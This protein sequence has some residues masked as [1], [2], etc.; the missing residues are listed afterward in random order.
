MEDSH[1]ANPTYIL[2]SHLLVAM[3]AP[4]ALQSAF[5]SHADFAV[6][7]QAPLSA[8]FRQVSQAS[9]IFGSVPF[10]AQKLVAHSV[11]HVP[12]VAQTQYAILHATC[13]NS[14]R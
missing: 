5:P 6:A 8:V 10:C 12:G 9:P 4:M 3:Q 14:N 7:P 13:R 1:G 2:A 11:L